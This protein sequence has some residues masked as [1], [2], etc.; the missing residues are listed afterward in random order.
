MVIPSL[1]RFGELIKPDGYS[2]VVVNY[3]QMGCPLRFA[4]ETLIN[5][6]LREDALGGMSCKN[7]CWGCGGPTTPTCG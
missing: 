2:H 3:G 1:K 4:E 5:A 6:G 7:T